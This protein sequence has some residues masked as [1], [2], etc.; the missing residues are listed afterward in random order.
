MKIRKAKISDA[1]DLAS[2]YTQFWAAHKTVDPLIRLSSK[3][4]EKEDLRYAKSSLKKKDTFVFIALEGSKIIGYI[5]LFI[6]KNE[7][8][9]KVKK[10]GY[11]DTAVVDKKHRGK[12]VTR[13]LTDSAF[14][15][16]KKNGID[17]I[18]TNVYNANDVALKVWERLGFEQL[19]V[20]MIKKI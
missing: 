19:S 10:Y 12:G 5:E 13:L 8:Y 1:K 2:L 4:Q 16:L 11:L 6:A 15:F 17:Y 3:D 18:K 7:P 9:Y 14:N 20:N